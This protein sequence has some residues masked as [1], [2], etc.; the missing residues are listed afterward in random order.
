VTDDVAGTVWPIINLKTTPALGTA[1]T[2][3]DTPT[4]LPHAG[5]QYD[6]G[7]GACQRLADHEFED[8]ATLGTAVTGMTA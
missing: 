3:I 8:D 5:R 2:G 1:V 4:V 6:L 7:D